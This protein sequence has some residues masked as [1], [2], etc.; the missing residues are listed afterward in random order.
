MKLIR[1]KYIRKWVYDPE[2]YLNYAPSLPISCGRMT[3]NLTL[4]KANILTMLN[5]S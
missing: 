2:Y 4:I 1:D 5:K 3:A